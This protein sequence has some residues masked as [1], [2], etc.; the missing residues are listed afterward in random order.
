MKSLGSLEEAVVVADILQPEKT[1]EMGTTA[2]SIKLLKGLKS[3]TPISSG[4]WQTW[5]GTSEPGLPIFVR[6]EGWVLR[7]DP[8]LERAEPILGDLTRTQWWTAKPIYYN[9]EVDIMS[10]VTKT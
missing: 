8:L 4:P 1:E 7:E 6:D 2:A 9:K 3:H 10:C 5:D